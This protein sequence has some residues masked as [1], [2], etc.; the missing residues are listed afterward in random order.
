MS[1]P[2]KRPELNE[3][4]QHLLKVLVERYIYE[5]QPVGS[6]ALSRD[7][8]LNLS[9]ATI[10]NVMADLEDLGLIT[11][12]HTSAG[13]MPT[14]SGYRL[15]VDTLLTIK[16]LQQEVVQQFRREMGPLHDP[17]EIVETASRLLADVTHMAGLVS[18]PRVETVTFRMIEFLPLSEQRILV[19]LV[20]NEREV[21]NRI[22]SPAR[23]FSPA[24][25][26]AAANY[27]N[28]VY[29]GKD[30]NAIRT[31]LLQE[32]QSTR[33]QMNQ[34]ALHAAEI[35]DLALGSREARKRKPFVLAGETNLM[36]FDELASMERL[37]GLFA[38]FRQKEDLV[39]L[40]DRC[41]EST[42][43]KIYIGEE[44][45]YR[46]LDQC[47]LVTA[48]YGIDEQTIGVLG[49]IGPTRMEYERVIPLVDLTAKMLSAALN[50]K[51]LTPS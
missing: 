35:A 9:P 46:A 20:T 7:A 16:P 48:S 41:L 1:R 21:Q 17:E 31:S 50:Q 2:Q 44:S 4:A 19:I 15:F 38:A 25:L 45:G 18:L 3:R 36:D 26:T 39:H 23:R 11:A 51:A 12:P 13:R 24:E 27:L 5:G 30:L 49:V 32:L 6:R 40:L 47:S 8:G 14:V 10:R 33:E 43:V 37:R 29:A 42:G 22:I 28:A 34:E